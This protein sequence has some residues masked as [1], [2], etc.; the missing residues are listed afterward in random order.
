MI[1]IDFSD[2]IDVPASTRLA[3]TENQVNLFLKR[4]LKE[5][6]GQG[7][8]SGF[9]VFK[10]YVRFTPGVCH[11]G[12]EQS[13]FDSYSIFV[14]TD[15]KLA[16][17]NDK[18]VATNI[19]GSFGRVNVHPVL[20]DGLNYMFQSFWDAMKRENQAMQHLQSID[21]DKGRVTMVVRGGGK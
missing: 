3:Y 8:L 4:T 21:I 12:I 7:L 16:V 5:K 6:P 10:A 14:D 9:V 2:A 18:F 15:Y 1:S 20:M 19:G 17:V 11:I 13:L